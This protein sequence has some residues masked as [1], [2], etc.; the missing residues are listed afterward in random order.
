MIVAPR[1]A[2]PPALAD[3]LKGSWSGGNWDEDPSARASWGV[4]GSQPRNFIYQREN[5]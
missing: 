4:F 2:P 3:Y 5:F 1:I